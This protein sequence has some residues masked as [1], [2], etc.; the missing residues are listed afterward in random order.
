MLNARPS[1]EERLR[2]GFKYFNRFM[3]LMWR[4]GL[5]RSLSL[6]PAVG[7]RIMVLVHTG[8]KSGRLRTTPL[9]FAELDGHIYCTAGFGQISDWYRN[10]CADPRVEIWL[11][12]GCW[13]GVAEEVT[14]EEGALPRVRE[15]LKGSGIVAPLFGVNPYTLSDTDLAA[16]TQTYRLVRVRRTAPRPS[17]GDLAWAWPLALA[18]LLVL[19]ALPRRRD[20]GNQMRSC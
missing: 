16:A 15:V 6:W 1:A 11:P 12:D 8:R 18:A 4:L 17:P 5:G 2:R 10:V 13:S 19:R 3:L 9:N 7:G 14:G 20:A